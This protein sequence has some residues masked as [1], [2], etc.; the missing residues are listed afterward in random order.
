M[1]TVVECQFCFAEDFP[2]QL[3]RF[4]LSHPRTVCWGVVV[5][6]NDTLSIC[7][8]WTFF[9]DEWMDGFRMGEYHSCTRASSGPNVLPIST[10]TTVHSTRL[11]VV[12]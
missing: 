5:M 7:Q 1:T 11:H 6:K 8:S 2:A 4:V 9:F 3:V 12:S 10:P